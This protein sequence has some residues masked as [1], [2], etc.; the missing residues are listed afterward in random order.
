[1][2]VQVTAA[3][4]ARRA[5]ALDA[6]VE[7]LIA[8]HVRDEDEKRE[9][10]A[11]LT[12]ARDDAGAARASAHQY[13]AAMEQVGALSLWGAS[14][15]EALVRQLWGAH[16]QLQT[17]A[18]L[19]G[20]LPSAFITRCVQPE[21]CSSAG[22]LSTLKVRCRKDR[23]ILGLLVQRASGAWTGRWGYL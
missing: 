9:L 19:R 22:W 7:R 1:M 18:T 13:R 4:E 12:A 6:K 16:S 11:Q 15:T 23:M 14:L 20:F 5:A 21:T 3:N 8:G 10:Y 2:L 17:R